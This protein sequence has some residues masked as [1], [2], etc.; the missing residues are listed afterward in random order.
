[1]KRL[2]AVVNKKGKTKGFTD[3]KMAAKRIRRKLNG[4][5]NDEEGNSVENLAQGYRVA[6]GPDHRRYHVSH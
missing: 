6:L 3:D 1:M 2:F 5:I 4:V